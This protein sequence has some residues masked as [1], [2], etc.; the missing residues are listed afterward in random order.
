MNLDSPSVKLCMAGNRAEL[1]GRIDDARSLF[2][3]A[4][5]AAANEYDAC[6]AAHYMARHQ[7]DPHE[8]LRWNTIALAQAGA[9]TDESV[10]SFYPSLYVN[11]GHSYEQLGQMERASHF[12]ALA[13]ERGLT[14]NPQQPRNE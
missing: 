8:A 2:S 6:V 3:Q 10:A 5:E 11:L 1:E 13:A 14:H 9:V 4:W 12:Y 7:A